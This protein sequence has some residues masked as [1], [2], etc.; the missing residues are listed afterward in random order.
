MTLVGSTR[1]QLREFRRK[2][3]TVERRLVTCNMYLLDV[4]YTLNMSANIAN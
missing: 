4:D 2:L 1:S 3:A